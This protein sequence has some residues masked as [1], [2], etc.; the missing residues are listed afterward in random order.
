M[1]DKLISIRIEDVEDQLNKNNF[2]RVMVTQNGKLI[3][4]LESS[5][6]PEL[7]KYKSIIKN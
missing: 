7:L 4:I 3:Q 1:N 6:C 2:F 5:K